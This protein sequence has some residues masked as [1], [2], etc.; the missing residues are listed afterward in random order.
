[1]EKKYICNKC[2]TEY[3]SYQGLYQHSKY[4]KT[5]GA[6]DLSKSFTCE[7]CLKVFR[8][9]S[10]LS[11]HRRGCKMIKNVI[12]EKLKETILHLDQ[13]KKKLNE[14]LLLKDKQDNKDLKTYKKFAKEYETV[15]LNRDIEI[16]E[17]KRK[18]LQLE[19]SLSHK[20]NTTDEKINEYQK[21]IESLQSR[22]EESNKKNIEYEKVINEQKNKIEYQASQIELL[23][24][25]KNDI[26]QYIRKQNEK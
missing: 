15:L 21:I 2:E 4:S 5:C 19:E 13:E 9:P 16:Q 8:G 17:C 23:N 24:T 18:I 20:Q 10:S 12:V 1:M 22:I 7:F 11:E 6:E 3:K 26:L 14:E 25:Y